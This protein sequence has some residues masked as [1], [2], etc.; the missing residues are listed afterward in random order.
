MMLVAFVNKSILKSI[1]ITSN[2]I[3]SK[4]IYSENYLFT[5]NGRETEQRNVSFMIEDRA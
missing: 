4:V 1:K 2:W 5:L 3:M